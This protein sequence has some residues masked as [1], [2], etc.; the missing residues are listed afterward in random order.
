MVHLDVPNSSKPPLA[1]AW[2]V[3]QAQCPASHCAL[4]AAVPYL[5]YCPMGVQLP[6][7]FVSHGTD[8]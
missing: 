3:S 2:I 6:R 1:T 7:V 8:T 5:S 4:I